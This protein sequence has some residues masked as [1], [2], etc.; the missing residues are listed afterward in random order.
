MGL[1]CGEGWCPGQ[2]LT[3]T[4]VPAQLPATGKQPLSSMCPAIIVGQDGQVR[5]A[6]GASGGTQITTATALVCTPAPTRP[7]PLGPCLSRPSPRA[8][9]APR[10]SSTACGL[11][12]M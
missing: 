2:Q 1:R 5:M 9:S 11:A 3:R 10:P 12:T 8:D 4:P 6:V 7:S